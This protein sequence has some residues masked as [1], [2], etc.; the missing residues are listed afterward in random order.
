MATGKWRQP[1]VRV[2][3]TKQEE[4]RRGEEVLD[5]NL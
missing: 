2:L 5:A 3:L 1:P 4:E